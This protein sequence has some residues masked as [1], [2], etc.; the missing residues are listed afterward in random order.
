LSQRRRRESASLPVDR[1]DS[2]EMTRDLEGGPGKKAK[3]PRN[4]GVGEGF[5]DVKRQGKHSGQILEGPE[6]HKPRGGI[7]GSWQPCFQGI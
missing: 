7:R 5:R 1:K 3:K 2:Y 6:Y 4:W